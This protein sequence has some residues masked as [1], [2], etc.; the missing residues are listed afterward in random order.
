[1]AGKW[2]L[3]Q[4]PHIL[5][6]LCSR[7]TTHTCTLSVIGMKRYSPRVAANPRRMATK[8]HVHVLNEHGV[9]WWRNT[10][11]LWLLIAKE[12]HLL[13]HLLGRS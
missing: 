6:R 3:L 9:E 4:H 12:G 1:M 11:A 2:Q 13:G 5:L 7:L 8:G 10:R